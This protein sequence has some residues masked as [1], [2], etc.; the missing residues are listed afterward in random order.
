MDD[1]PHP[2]LAY[3]FTP[4][5][6]RWSVSWTFLWR[7]LRAREATLNV[8]CTYSLR[9]NISLEKRR[10]TRNSFIATV[11]DFHSKIDIGQLFC[12]CKKF[13]CLAALAMAKSVRLSVC[14]T[15]ESCLNA[16]QR[17]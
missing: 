14:N 6:G 16:V 2:R 3:L 17:I 15:R 4:R 5:L 1:A 13:F 9:V 7:T 10:V 12:W 8:R 11:A